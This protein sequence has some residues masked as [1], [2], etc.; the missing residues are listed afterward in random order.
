MQRNAQTKHG[1]EAQ[2]RPTGWTPGGI[3]VIW[4]S[5]EPQKHMCGWGGRVG[6][7]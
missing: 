3:F 2:I 4:I 1:A 7:A 5:W 6:L